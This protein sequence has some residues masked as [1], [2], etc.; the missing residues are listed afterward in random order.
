MVLVGVNVPK[1]DD[2]AGQPGHGVSEFVVDEVVV[3]V[4]NIHRNGG[5]R[6]RFGL[7][8]KH[9]VTVGVVL[10]TKSRGRHATDGH[11]GVL[12]QEV[13][14]AE[15]I[16]VPAGHVVVDVRGGAGRVVHHETDLDILVDFVGQIDGD[17]GPTRG[18]LRRHGGAC[19]T[20]AP[21]L[22][23]QS[24]ATAIG[25]DLVVPIRARSSAKGVVG[26]LKQ[27]GAVLLVNRE[28][29]EPGVVGREA[30]VGRGTQLKVS[31]ISESERVLLRTR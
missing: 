24:E 2:V 25:G 26:A 19:E 29:F 16:D 23:A 8:G 10:S 6:G 13:A 4:E 9:T 18:V 12:G 17:V 14:Q 21:L 7:H 11:A 31:T 30:W 22:S 27:A 3:R 15:V 20:V 5:G 28:I 1:F